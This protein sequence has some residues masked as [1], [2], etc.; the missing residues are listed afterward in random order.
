[1]EACSDYFM[2][3]NNE[4]VA[5][6]H[7][8][9]REPL[10]T[11][12]LSRALAHAALPANW[13]TWADAQGEE[14]D[15]DAVQRFREQTLSDL[16]E[17]CYLQLRAPFLASLDAALAP[18]APWQH[19]EAALFALRA[20]VLPLRASALGDGGGGGG[21]GEAACAF[22][23]RVCGRIAAEEQLFSAH[24]L[25]VEAACR[26]L[27]AYAAWLGRSPAARPAVHGCTAF[28]LRALGVPTALPHAAAALRNV[29]ARCAD[30]LSDPPT[31]SS[32]IATAHACLPPP[33]PPPP[34]GAEPAAD[35]RGTVVE[36][37]ARLVAKLPPA[38]ASAAG[39]ALTGPIVA[40][41]GALISSASAAAAPSDAASH[42]LAA[43]LVLLAAAVRF[44]EC[45]G[46]ATSGAPPALAVLQAAWPVLSCVGE[47][48]TWRASPP[49]AAALAEV[50]SRAFLCARAAAAPLLPPAL[51]TLLAAFE[52]HGHAPCADALATAVEVFA[53][54]SAHDI[55][56]AH[57]PLPPRDPALDAALAD[58][59]E[60]ASAAAMAMC[61][62]RG[63]AAA[64]DTLRALFELAHR[65]ALFAPPLLLR[66]PAIEPLLALAVEGI[67]CVRVS[68]TGLLRV[69]VDLHA[70]CSLGI[71][72]ARPMP[73][74]SA[75][76]LRERE[77][78]RAAAQ[79]LQ[80]LLSPGRQMALWGDAWRAA[81]PALD[82]VLSRYGAPL[83]A[84]LCDAGAATAQRSIVQTLGGVLY[85]LL[86]AYP[87]RASGIAA[88]GV[89]MCFRVH[90]LAV[91]CVVSCAHAR[92][93][94]ADDALPLV[95]R[96]RP[97]ERCAAVAGDRHRS[98]HVPWRRRCC[99]RRRG[100][101]HAG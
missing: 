80:A 97:A 51:A 45:A 62:A 78:C 6:R 66:G 33:P 1:M 77:P 81:R 60:R 61:V 99:R 74:S 22:L 86:S 98:A 37:L 57:A 8:S 67:K 91:H 12:L 26:M 90:A 31:L 76:R 49:V 25:V 9:L 23:A 89:H 21:D 52:A 92:A 29:C 24:P 7:P 85:A 72:N 42:A 32:L 15:E 100:Q 59:L 11:A 46:D 101:R 63:A 54:P 41:A 75:R 87:V 2:H 48:V 47:S 34:S 16:L 64:P 53:P 96:R 18:G 71:T 43:E 28:L 73:R 55:A 44:M 56:S 58:A 83:A 10:F 94:C 36:G 5:S 40:R 14:E 4:P 69:A 65:A 95:M 93:L 79:L 68:C 82:A 3:I 27:G 35:D 38:E 70:C 88:A 13:R 20:V 19:A 84:A 50:Y 30:T 39:L 17:C